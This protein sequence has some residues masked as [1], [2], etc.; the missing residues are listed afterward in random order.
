M[1]SIFS[2]QVHPLKQLV[3]ALGFVSVI[4]LVA[5]GLMSSGSITEN[6]VFFWEICL[7][8]L[9]SYAVFNC[10]FSLTY[11]KRKTYFPFSILSFAFLAVGGGLLAHFLS[12]ISVDEAG[13]IRW[14]LFVFSFSYLVFISII[15]MMK[16]IMDFAQKQ[17]AR[18][19]G[20]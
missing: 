4:M 8:G 16:L 20:E 19:R 11:K 14:L 1:S 10:V 7:A 13:S 12:G 5:K 15:N 17:D 2:M 3:F 6:P 9:L 18:L